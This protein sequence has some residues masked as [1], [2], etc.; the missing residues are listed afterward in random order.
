MLCMV[1][2]RLEVAYV[3]FI[4]N[5]DEQYSRVWTMVMGSFEL[6]PHAMVFL[7]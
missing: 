3:I 5:G 7:S 1:V 2:R 4:S 6:I